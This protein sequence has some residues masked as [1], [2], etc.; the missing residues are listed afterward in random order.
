M[1]TKKNSPESAV[2]LGFLYIFSQRIPVGQE[3]IQSKPTA[4]AHA[5]AHAVPWVARTAAITPAII[6]SLSLLQ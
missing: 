1:K 5:D 3:D 4:S 6:L 2:L